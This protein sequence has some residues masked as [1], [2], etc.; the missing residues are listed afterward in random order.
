MPAV[1]RVSLKT[2]PTGVPV[3]LPTEGE[4]RN[5]LRKDYEVTCTSVHGATTWSWQLSF[6]PESSGPLGTAPPVDSYSRV[7]STANL[8]STVTQQT[9][10]VV[11]NEGAYLVRL[12]VDAGL[13]TEDVQFVRLRVKT[14]FAELF[15]IA[16]GE[17]RDES[18]VIPV[19]IDP[20]GWA[21]EQNSNIQ[22]LMLLVR[23]ASMSGRVL[24]VD[25]NI[26]RSFDPMNPP[27]PNDP[28]TIIRMPGPETGRLD[29][30]GMRIAC[31]GFGDF[32]S[33]QAGI[34]YAADCVSRGEAPLDSFNPYFIKIAPGFFQEDLVLVPHVHLIADIEAFGLPTEPEIALMI[35]VGIMNTNV[36]GAHHEFTAIQQD[37]ICIL[38]GIFFTNTTD[39]TEPIFH[40]QGGLLVFDKSSIIQSGADPVQGPLILS[41]L[42]AP[43]IFP[44]I[45]LIDSFAYMQ[46]SDPALHAFVMA[47]PGVFYA[48]D[49]N[50]WGDTT[51]L[52]NS[53]FVNTPFGGE[54][55][56]ENSVVRSMT[57]GGYA[58]RGLPGNFVCVDSEFDN[59]DLPTPTPILSFELV[60]TAGVSALAGAVGYD[61]TL[62]ISTSDILGDLNTQT[63]QTTGDV[64]LHPSSLR[65]SG[66]YLFPTGAPTEW[67]PRTNS[68][69]VFYDSAY[70]D[71]LEPVGA[72]T[73]LPTNK[74][75]NAIDMLV[76]AAL[77]N[78]TPPY[79]SLNTAY[80]GLMNLLP[81][82]YGDGD[83]REITADAGAIKIGGAVT[84]LTD[85][86]TDQV[87]TGGLQAEGNVDLG[88]MV[89]STPPIGALDNL[90]SEI[91][92]RPGTF[93]GVAMMSM[94][95]SSVPLG[96]SSDH[97]GFPGGIIMGGNPNAMNATGGHVPFNLHLR[98]R[99]N[100]DSDT[101]E[102]GSVVVQGGDSYS[103]S[104]GSIGAPGTK[105]G[106]VYIQGG[107]CL[108]RSAP[109]AEEGGFIF[110]APGAANSSP[111]VG[112]WT[113]S[114]IRIVKPGDETGSIL[115]AGAAFVPGGEG[116]FYLS[117]LN[118]VEQ[119]SVSAGDVLADVVTTINQTSYQFLASTSG[120]KLRLVS[121]A[122][123]PNSD[124]L[125]VASDP[126]TLNTV[127][128]GELRVGSGATFTP[129]TYLTYVDIG[130][131]DTDELTV[132]GDI[133]ATGD[134][135][136]GGSCCGGGGGSGWLYEIVD[137]SVGPSPFPLNLNT[138]TAGIRNPGALPGQS[139]VLPAAAVPGQEV[140]LKDETGNAG[141][142][143]VMIVDA[144]LRPIEGLPGL[145]MNVN[146]Q[147]YRVYFTGGSWFIS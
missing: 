124:V 36:P 73:T 78:P 39:T 122:R 104:T 23:R 101:G 91:N 138:T 83:G 80:D 46:T 126:G 74:V 49:S 2:S 12:V 4:S 29:E 106:S 141:I 123:G 69:S 140:T 129:G 82:T 95:R 79:Y 136:A 100:Y 142:A 37:D 88:P 51:V 3:G 60:D 28:N 6:A 17:R 66:E 5:D 145:L 97:R 56:F 139:V 54:V 58:F 119:F 53:N 24:H 135:T 18:G 116:T 108:Q 67:T 146:G 90:G 96:F 132:Y 118:G 13:P 44:G 113:P 40:Q 134:I 7:D 84:P 1:I 22:R 57:S 120:G 117:G 32:S 105:G 85:W 21:N 77:P 94:G 133:H 27:T 26:G 143:P 98:T 87:L 72:P 25:A 59:E 147:A 144:L 8:S 30:T 20:Q 92:L 99:N 109:G 63:D 52:F 128:L 61:V 41:E 102:L 111:F 9:K 93:A 86:L 64:N 43:D 76:G 45:M 81:I 42:V 121:V 130:C 68:T 75:Q 14:A 38:R 137:F 34:N 89:D 16:A 115:T 114:K 50:L 131:T 19:D 31:E 11:D 127:N 71:P 65:V 62:D 125:F 103:D 15:L 47:D 33:I 35:P 107:V 70:V 10:F 55:R 112:A 110:L 48:R